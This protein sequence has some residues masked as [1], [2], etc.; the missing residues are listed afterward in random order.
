MGEPRT[1]YPVGRTDVGKRLDH[2]LHERIPK[3]SRTRIQTMI[4]TRVFL[5]WEA[6][7]RPATILVKGGDVHI[8]FQ[9]VPE[10]LL[11][12]RIPVLARGDGWMALDKPAGLPVHP[13]STVRENTVI[14]MIRRQEETESLTLAHRLDRETSG[15]LILADNRETASRLAV[16]FEQRKVH[17]EYLAVINGV[18][19]EDEGNIDLPVGQAV[20]SKVHVRQVAGTGQPAQTRWVVET[21]AADSTLVRLFP[22]TGRQHQIRVHMEAIGHP[23]VGDM[24]Y[25]RPDSDFLDM[26]TGERNAREEEGAPQRHLL[27]C[28]RICFKADDLAL[29]CHSPMPASFTDWLR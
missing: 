13:H 3:L 26:V 9:P 24:L 19:E 1:L 29:D 15:V 4:R 11:D 16:A 27:H 25:G 17:K 6:R 10:T 2:F 14:R 18:L 7:V 22:H 5:S 20:E 21:R 23:V 28:A 12:I 8:A